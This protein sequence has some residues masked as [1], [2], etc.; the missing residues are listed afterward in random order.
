MVFQTTIPVTIGMLFTRWNLGFM[1]ALAVVLG[2]GGLVYLMLMSD[3]PLQGTISVT[4]R[5]LLCRLHRNGNT[6]RLIPLD[7]RP[8]RHWFGLFK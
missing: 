1:D 2:S 8:V 6:H 3:K 4:R 7:L 5:G